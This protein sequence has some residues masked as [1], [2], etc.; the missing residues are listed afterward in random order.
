MAWRARANLCTI[1]HMREG[2]RFRQMLKEMIDARGTSERRFEDDFKL[3]KWSLRGILDPKRAQVPSIDKA[4]EICDAL[5]LEFYI[6]PP[7]DRPGQRLE[8]AG[9]EFASVPLYDP[10]A[11]AGPGDVVEAEA[12]TGE[13]AFRLAWLRKRG[14]VPDQAALFR[15]RGESMAPTIADQ[16]LILVDRAARE[17]RDRRIYLV[18]QGDAL[19]VKRLHRDAA[20]S[21]IATSDNPLHPAFAL[22]PAAGDRPV[23]GEVRWTARTLDH[24]RAARQRRPATSFEAPLR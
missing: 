4:K 17:P 2:E 9:E 7:R 24:S 6:G 19:Y 1:V 8:L 16:A 15:V 5:G 21:V 18:R 12:V 22:D 14:I 20:G 11:S 23:L 10:T 3:P 13:L